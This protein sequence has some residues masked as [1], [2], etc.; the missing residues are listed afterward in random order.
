MPMHWA[1]LIAGLVYG[2]RGGAISGLL[3]PV[4][5]FLITGM[6]YAAMLFP[7]T[8]ELFTY[9]IIVGLLREVFK[10]NPFISVTIAVTGSRIVFIVMGYASGIISTN[11]FMYAENSILPGLAAA[12]G[13]IM[14]L[15]FIS[16]MVDK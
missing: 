1:V 8:L 14:F 15:P 13:Q 4:T 9:G 11:L 7:M 6:P 12:A 5:S 3:S 2:W 16:K 10:K